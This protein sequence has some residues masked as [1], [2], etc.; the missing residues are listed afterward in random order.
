MAIPSTWGNI[1]YSDKVATISDTLVASSR[2][3]EIGVRCY[4][5]EGEFFA[6]VQWY[7]NY[8]MISRSFNVGVQLN[9]MQDYPLGLLAHYT[10]L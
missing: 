5:N 6:P 8:N 3:I 1:W 4:E 7:T 10:I 9:C 2:N